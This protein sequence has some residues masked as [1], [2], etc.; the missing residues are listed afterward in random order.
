MD[1]NQEAKTANLTARKSLGEILVEGNFI[2]NEQLHD[3]LEQAEKFA[4]V[5]MIADGA[6][7]EST[8]AE[9][10]RVSFSIVIT[11]RD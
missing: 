9:T 4:E 6:S 10:T 5:R 2:T 7:A 3:A 1:K 11:R 8:A